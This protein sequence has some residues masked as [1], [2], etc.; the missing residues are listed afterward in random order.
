MNFEEKKTTYKEVTENSDE[1][2]EVGVEEINYDAVEKSSK[3][4]TVSRKSWTRSTSDS[5]CT[6]RLKF[7]LVG[8]IIHSFIR[9][10]Y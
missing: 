3:N 5:T 9:S 4:L 10:Y 7:N 1:K 6:E 8:N 2:F